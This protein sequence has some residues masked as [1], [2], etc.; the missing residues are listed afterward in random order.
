[1]YC[2]QRISQSLDV[3]LQQYLSPVDVPQRLNCLI[4]PNSMGRTRQGDSQH[5]YAI[6]R[7]NK[8]A[9]IRLVVACSPLALTTAHHGASAYPW[10]TH[11]ILDI[12]IVLL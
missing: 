7:L 2:Q 4:N 10:Q 5:V 9:K 12:R 8:H 3:H 6:H 11:F 1:M